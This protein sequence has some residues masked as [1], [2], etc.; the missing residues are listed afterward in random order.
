MSSNIQ[1]PLPYSLNPEVQPIPPLPF[2][3]YIFFNLWGLVR[4]LIKE[5]YKNKK[6]FTRIGDQILLS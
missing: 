2:K 6:K 4:K 3:L 5:N 1:I